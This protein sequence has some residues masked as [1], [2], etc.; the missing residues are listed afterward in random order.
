M[1]ASASTLIVGVLK[2]L[3]GVCLGVVQISNHGAGALDGTPAAIAVLPSIAGAMRDSAPIVR[4]S[5]IPRILDEAK[6]A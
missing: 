4:E 3:P 2:R 5:R 1:G 6:A